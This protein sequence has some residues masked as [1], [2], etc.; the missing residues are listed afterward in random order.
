MIEADEA[1]KAISEAIE[2]WGLVDD[3]NYEATAQIFE[4]LLEKGVV[5]SP[6]PEDQGD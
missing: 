2:Q 5:T 4:F 1:W 3:R 6:Y